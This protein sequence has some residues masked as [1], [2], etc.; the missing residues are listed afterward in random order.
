[1]T[2]TN[3]DVKQLIEEVLIDLGN[4]KSLTDVSSKI[5]IIV[6]LLGDDNLRDWF[7]CEFVKGY[8]DEELPDYRV[9]RA[10]DIKANYIVPQGFGAWSM[11]DQSVPM[12]NLGKE[13]YDEIMIIKLKENVSSIIECSKHPEKMAM[14]LS[15]YETALVQ[16]VLGEVHIR[17]VHKVIPPSAFQ[18]IIDN[19]QNRIID[20]FMDINE[21]VFNGELD[22]TSSQ[23]KKELQQVIFN[24]ITAGIVQTGSGTIDASHATIAANTTSTVSAEVKDKLNAIVDELERIVRDE[25]NAEI[26]QDLSDLRTELQA[27]NPQPQILKKS[28]KALVW[29]ASVTCKATIEKLVGDAIDL[30]AGLVS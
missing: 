18:H 26:K 30:L 15:P 6:R 11:P 20:M 21:K 2:K 4:N 19:V 9:T 27:P 8:T 23:G 25:D 7:N 16:K 29:G 5:Q 3:M 28:F 10:A 24:N 14:S 22:V 13:K 12:F 17:S 1:M